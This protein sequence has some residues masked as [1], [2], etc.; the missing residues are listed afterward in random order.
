MTPSSTLAI[1]SDDIYHRCS[2]KFFSKSLDRKWKF[3]KRSKNCIAENMSI[4]QVSFTSS[5]P[6]TTIPFQY[7]YRFDRELFCI[8]D[9]VV[10]YKIASRNYFFKSTQHLYQRACPSLIFSFSLTSHNFVL[11]MSI[12]RIALR[13][14][15]FKVRNQ[16]VFNFTTKNA[17]SA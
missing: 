12:A 1:N 17:L 10:V 2:D 9:C 7:I 5:W 4:P 14:I 11:K 15:S 8:C 3:N 6:Y 13:S 16:F